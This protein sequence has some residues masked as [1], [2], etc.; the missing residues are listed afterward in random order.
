M[1][2]LHEMFEREHKVDFQGE[3][4]QIPY[5][6]SNALGLGRPLKLI[7]HP[8]RNHIPIYLGSMG[9]KNVALAAEISDG[10]FPHLLSP[11][12][13]DALYRPLLENGFSKT[14]GSKNFNNFDIIAQVYV[15]V[16]EDIHACRRSVKEKLGLILGGYGAKQKNFYVNTVS[17]YGYGTACKQIQDLFL[18]GKK[19]EAIDSIPDELVDELAIV[20]PREHVETQLAKWQA[21]SIGGLALWTYEPEALRMIAD[22]VKKNGWE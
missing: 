5:K 3:H 8:V 10:W 17:Q 9:P 1:K 22:I 20:G 18:S 19:E 2:I 14:D 21:I 16:G 13:F 6:G 12:Q 11:L 4:Y 15:S 7:H